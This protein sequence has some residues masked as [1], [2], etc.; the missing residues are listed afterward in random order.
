MIILNLALSFLGIFLVVFIILYVAIA[1]Y[2]VNYIWHKVDL[3]RIKKKYYGGNKN[4]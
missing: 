2:L 1:D 3:T 4:E